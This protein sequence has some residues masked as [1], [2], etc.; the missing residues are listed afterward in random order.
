[1]MEIMIDSEEWTQDVNRARRLA[2]I[3]EQL[4]IGGWH[5]F[6]NNGTIVLMKDLTREDAERELRELDISEL[7]LDEWME[8]YIDA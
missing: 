6:G 4:T 7:K 1:M 2:I 3:L 5:K 8:Q